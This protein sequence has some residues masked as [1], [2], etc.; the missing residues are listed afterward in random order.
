MVGIDDYVGTANE[1]EFKDIIVKVSDNEPINIAAVAGAEVA[2]VGGK[3]KE[4]THDFDLSLTAARLGL[5][6]ELEAVPSGESP[7]K[8][9]LQA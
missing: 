9:A 7:A 4:E 5:L 6:L 8:T 1:A 3:T 2:K